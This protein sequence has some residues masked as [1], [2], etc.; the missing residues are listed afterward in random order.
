MAIIL[1]KPE[2]ILLMKEAGRITGEA[3]LVAR[4][5]IR[6]GISTKELDSLIHAY[7]LKCGAKPSFLGYGGF[8]GSAC[9]SVNNQIIHGIPS[10]KVFLHE[11]DIVKVDVGAIYRG[12]HGDSAKTFAVGR[13][14]EEAQKLIDATRESFYRGVS[15]ARVGNRL[16]DIGHAVQAYA[17][18][19]GYGVVRKYVGHGVGT[20]LHEEPDVPNYGTPGRGC[21]LYPGMTIAIEPMV[22]EGTAEIKELSDGWTVVTADG[23]LSAHYEH[24]VAIT[25]DGPILLTD[26]G[27]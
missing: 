18:S 22:N 2:Q 24:T 3:L 25:D 20:H 10:H 6:P 23:R 15:F 5:A 9:I 16:G 17:E 1:K 4:D 11:G 12:Y 26:V 27:E 14:S 19:C 21:R 8:P 13:V 7:I